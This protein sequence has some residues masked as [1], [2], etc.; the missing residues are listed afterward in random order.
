MGLHSRIGPLIVVLHASIPSHSQPQ[1]GATKTKG[2]TNASL[3]AVSEHQ[4][5]SPSLKVRLQRAYIGSG[6]ASW[7]SVSQPASH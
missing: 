6:I 5:Y 1:R 3:M 4:T 2:K 7:T